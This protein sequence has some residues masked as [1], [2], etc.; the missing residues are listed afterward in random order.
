MFLMIDQL[1]LSV[2]PAG[3]GAK[4]LEFSELITAP[5]RTLKGE[6]PFPVTAALP[7]EAPFTH[8]LMG[9]SQ[10]NCA[11]CHRAESPH[12]SIDGGFVSAGFRPDPGNLVPLTELQAELGKCDPAAERE[13]C[14]MLVALL[15]LGPV[16]QGAF[17]T[18][19][20]L[21]IQ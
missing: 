20:E 3:A 19:F 9:Q 7:L 16:K 8:V 6:L 12:P 15:G 2:V 4:L 1:I 18:K 17:S 21:F 10:T 5:S 11:L 14:L 13:R